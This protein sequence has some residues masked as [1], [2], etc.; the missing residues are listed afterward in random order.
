MV[1]HSHFYCFDRL[2][3]LGQTFAKLS[4][5]ELSPRRQSVVL[6]LLVPVNTLLQL[7]V[8]DIDHALDTALAAMDPPSSE[9][10]YDL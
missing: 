5:L 6:S 4:M 3:R 1:A 9:T 8:L 2:V 10:F 7:Q